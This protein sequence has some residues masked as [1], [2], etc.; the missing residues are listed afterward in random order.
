VIRTERTSRPKIPL[1]N[2][3]TRERILRAGVHLFQQQGYHGTGIVA[4]LDRAG[5]PK[6]SFY[7]HFPG[8]K[9]QLAVA[10][11]A[12]L[13]G[14]VSSFLDQRAAAGES[15]KSMVEGVARHLAEGIRRGERTRAALM[16]VLAQEAAPES[17][18]IA[19][20]VAAYADAVRQRLANARSR[21]SPHDA[22]RF[23]DQALAV[24]QGAALIARIEG[25]AE[26]AREIVEGWLEDRRAE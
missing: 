5:A 1:A 26:R 22:A 6:G 3:P 15:S 13:E 23:A 9:E 25:R 21:E 14:E 8:G 19:R 18:P 20:A 2:R 12:W 4:I 11:M 24:L 7:H 10:A 17:A 16:A